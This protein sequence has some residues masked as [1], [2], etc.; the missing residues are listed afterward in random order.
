MLK[1]RVLLA[2]S[3]ALVLIAVTFTYLFRPD[4]SIQPGTTLPSVKTPLPLP[5]PRQ[6]QTEAPAPALVPGKR[7]APVQGADERLRTSQAKSVRALAHEASITGRL[8]DIVAYRLAYSDCDRQFFNAIEA[9]TEKSD[10][11]NVGRERTVRD[12]MSR[13]DGYPETRVVHELKDSEGFGDLANDLL[14]PTQ[15]HEPD[16]A[17]AK[18]LFQRVL[19]SSSTLLLDYYFRNNL[20]ESYVALLDIEE[21]SAITPRADK[22]LARHAVNLLACRVRGNCAEVA[23]QDLKCDQYNACTASLESFASDHIFT[24]AE[25]RATPFRIEGSLNSSEALLTRFERI[26]SRLKELAC[27]DVQACN[28]PSAPKR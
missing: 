22:V 2:A 25:Q 1:L 27:K 26:Q 20:M 18:K 19:Q 15:K 16:N 13:C 8:T 5:L 21:A 4:T 14:M 28:T 12:I 11:V 17:Q 23:A 6:L 7:P 10:S 3:G 24:S 9:K